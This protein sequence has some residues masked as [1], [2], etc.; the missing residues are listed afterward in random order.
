M[1]CPYVRALDT[2]SK[3]IGYVFCFLWVL[4]VVLACFG[5][6]GLKY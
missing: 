2:A 6:W 5:E 3:V 4:A 1:S